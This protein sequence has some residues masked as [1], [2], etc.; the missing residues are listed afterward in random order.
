MILSYLLLFSSAFLAATILPFYSEVV[1][2]A[3]LRDGGDPIVL[4]SIATLGN[5]LG[6]V[7]NWLL[8]WYLLH[9]QDRRWF[10]F[11]PAQ[12]ERAQ[13]WFQ[14]YGFWTLLLAWM[15]VGGDAL[16]LIAGIMKVRLW[17]FLLLV[18]TGKALRYISVVYL[19][20]W[21]PV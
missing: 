6:A 13:R 16:T 8:G 9:F 18:G 7:V 14:R 17:L 10:Y 2:F 15:P 1:L 4:V 20:A 12:I 19:T 3:L 11:K 5:T 21:A